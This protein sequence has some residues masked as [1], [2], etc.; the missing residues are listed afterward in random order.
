MTK[1]IIQT[2]TLALCI[3]HSITQRCLGAQF[4]TQMGK[5]AVKL[6][7]PL[8][9][10]GIIGGISINADANNKH[11]NS[12]HMP[13]NVPLE[14]T[15]GIGESITHVDT[16]ATV[17]V[18]PSF[19]LSAKDYGILAVGIIG[20]ANLAWNYYTHRSMNKRNKRFDKDLS[21]V[22]ATTTETQNHLE[23]L[24]NRAKADKHL[25][26]ALHKKTLKTID[27]LERNLTK[28]LQEGDQQVIHALTEEITN[29]KQELTKL[30][31]SN[32]S[33]S[34]EKIDTIETAQRTQAET[35]S[36][37]DKKL[38]SVVTMVA[39]SI[40][41]TPG[42]SQWTATPLETHP[43]LKSLLPFSHGKLLTISRSNS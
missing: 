2:L 38:D 35:L 40:A 9:L 1:K 43:L 36:G 12:S 20:C 8:A 14:S 41:N 37:I 10:G 33:Q 31:Q 24:S 13:D 19:S 32:H 25:N 26:C 28:A 42:S 18:S 7:T 4:F 11:E 6:L 39:H 5:H 17:P 22:Q 30:A 21:Q 27:T 23:T 16:P 15:P 3:G 29:A 34:M